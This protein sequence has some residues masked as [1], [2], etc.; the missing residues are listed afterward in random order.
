MQRSRRSL[1]MCLD[2]TKADFSDASLL[3]N[4]PVFHMLVVLLAQD[5]IQ[6]HDSNIQ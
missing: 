6:L 3:D 5:L 1:N 2:L 4:I